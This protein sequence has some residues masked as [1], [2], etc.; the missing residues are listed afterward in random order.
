M[1]RS[2]A[3]YGKRTG[4]SLT[5]GPRQHELFI[6]RVAVQ[7]TENDVSDYIK[8]TDSTL[9]VISTERLTKPQRVMTELHI[10]TKQSSSVIT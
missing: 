4:T 10:P 3:I 5:A 9:R 6:F 7:Y 8:N 2:N 1:R